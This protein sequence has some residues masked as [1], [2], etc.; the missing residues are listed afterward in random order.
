MHKIALL[1]GPGAGKTT[2]ANALT[3]YMKS[4]GL[5]WYNIPEYARDFINRWGVDEL[6]KLGPWGPYHIAMKQL[7]REKNVPESAHG[8]V[9]DS[10]LF[11]PYFYSL[12]VCRSSI[13]RFVVQDELYQM[14]LH[15]LTDYTVVVHVTREKKYVQDGTRFQTEDEA[16]E[17]DIQVANMLTMHGVRLLS[18][19]GD[20]HERVKKIAKFIGVDGETEEPCRQNTSLA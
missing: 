4:K 10:P 15:A 19:S 9:T 11:L 1:A 12:K 2:L 16:R 7:R 6:N 18:V 3:A 13:E 20:T 14:F 17:I 8:F 5:V